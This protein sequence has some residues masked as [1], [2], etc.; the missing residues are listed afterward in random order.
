MRL[1][2]YP[3]G[4]REGYK[5]SFNWRVGVDSFILN[6]YLKDEVHSSSYLKLQKMDE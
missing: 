1:K 3:E 6:F 4:F 2:R 5:F